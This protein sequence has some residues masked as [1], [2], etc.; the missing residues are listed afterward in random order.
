VGSRYVNGS[1]RPVIVNFLQP[2][3][4]LGID[5]ECGPLVDLVLPAEK[6]LEFFGPE[7]FDGVIST[8]LLEYVQDLRLIINKMKSVLRTGGYIS[9]NTFIWLSLSC[10]PL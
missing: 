9:L 1:V 2:S 6:L 5:I 10:I 3:R 8:E 7:S 4:Y